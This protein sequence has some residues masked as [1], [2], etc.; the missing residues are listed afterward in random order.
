[1]ISSLVFGFGHGSMWLA[2]LVAGYL[3]GELLRRTGRI[4]ESVAAHI[5]TNA[6]LAIAALCAGHWELL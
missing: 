1:L 4:G 2:G 6:L 3:Y 5:T